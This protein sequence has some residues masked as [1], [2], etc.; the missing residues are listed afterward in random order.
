MGRMP[1][2]ILHPLPDQGE[3]RARVFFRTIRVALTP[4]LS[5]IRERE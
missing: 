1:S 2:H 5:L 3:G 4:T